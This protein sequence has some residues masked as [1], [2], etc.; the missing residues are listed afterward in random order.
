MKKHWMNRVVEMLQVNTVVQD[1][2]FRGLRDLV[3]TKL[4]L[5]S[6]RPLVNR[7]ILRKRLG[8]IPK[9][10]MALRQ[11]LLGRALQKCRKDPD[12]MWML[13]SEN[14]SDVI[15][16]LGERG[17][18]LLSAKEPDEPNTGCWQKLRERLKHLLRSAKAGEGVDGILE[19]SFRK[20]ENSV[21]FDFGF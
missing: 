17:G 1:I 10:P 2:G 16:M 8:A 6:V 18:K 4:Y 14:V 5:K 3:G 20:S 21:L 19:D 7:N 9:A 11:K 12:R 15:L 13:V